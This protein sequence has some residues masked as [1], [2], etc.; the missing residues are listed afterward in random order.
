MNNKPGLFKLHSLRNSFHNIKAL[1][2]WKIPILITKAFFTAILAY[3]NVYVLS[4]I[5]NLL[6]SGMDYKA[7]LKFI[8]VSLVIIFAITVLT[9]YLEKVDKVRSECCYREYKLRKSNKLMEMNLERVESHD[10]KKILTRLHTEESYGFNLKLLFQNFD[11]ITGHMISIIVSFLFLVY[12]MSAEPLIYYL[13]MFLFICVIVGVSILVSIVTKKANEAALGAIRSVFPPNI[14]LNDYLAYEGGIRY[15]DGKDIRMYQYNHLVEKVYNDALSEMKG[16]HKMGGTRPAIMAGISGMTKGFT[17]C[18]SFLFVLT[19]MK[20][21]FDKYGWILMLT[22]VIYQLSIAIIGI[23]VAMSQY[24]AVAD[25][26]EQYMNFTESEKKSEESGSRAELK[27]YKLEIRNL[28]FAYHPKEEKVLKNINLKI[29]QG[30]KVAIVGENGSGKTTLVKLI[31]GLYEASQGSIFLGG[32]DIHEILKEDY[33]K[34]F[35]VVFQDFKLFSFQLEEVITAGETYNEDKMR[36]ILQTTGCNKIKESIPQGA[37][38]YIY[39]D[40]EDGVEVSGGEAQRLAIARAFYRNS[41]I[42]IFDEP[43]AALDPIGE[44]EVY[45]QIHEIENDKTVIFISHRLSACRFCDQIIVMDKGEIIQCGTHEEL[46]MEKEGKY[47]GLWTAQ[48]KYF[49]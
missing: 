23:A 37:K 41:P 1:D 21:D 35:A 38:T 28:S 36:L 42:L 49:V 10:T 29:E 13:W 20:V 44:Y 22:S 24:I 32:K 45:K 8:F 43:T 3:G 33:M 39:K 31:C 5:I 6:T 16:F 11:D 30:N 17:L 12:F 48:S 9:R 27:N 15:K 14:I 46:L 26:I 19:L 7:I 4:Q 47:F 2:S 40:Y 25:S 18:A 34:K